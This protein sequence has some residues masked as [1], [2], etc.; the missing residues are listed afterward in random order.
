MWNLL[1]DQ[2]NDFLGQQSSNDSYSQISLVV[3]SDADSVSFGAQDL[4]IADLSD[5]IV[6]LQESKLIGPD[7]GFKLFSLLEYLRYPSSFLL[8]KY[9]K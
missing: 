3:A 5:Q 9:P 7:T 2:L 4:N 1:G 8:G 6:L